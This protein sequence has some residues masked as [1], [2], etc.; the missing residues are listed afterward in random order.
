MDDRRRYV[1]ARRNLA[2][3]SVKQRVQAYGYG[4]R[5]ELNLAAPSKKLNSNK[6]YAGKLASGKFILLNLASLSRFCYK[7]K[8]KCSS[9][10]SHIAMRQNEK[11]YKMLGPSLR[12]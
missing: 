1:K 3:S 10:K 5:S 8:F 12:T 7:Y 6:I 9:A 2:L 11:F 4:L